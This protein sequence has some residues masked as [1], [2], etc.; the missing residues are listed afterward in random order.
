MDNNENKV[1]NMGGNN[2]GS[3]KSDVVNQGTQSTQPYM[4]E[5]PA[6]AIDREFIVPTDIVRL[7]SGGVFYKNKQSS[8]EIK[9]MTAEDENILTSADLIRSGKVLDVLLEKKIIDRNLRPTDMLTGD[10]NAVLFAIRS[11]GYGDDYIVSMTCPECR[12]EFT[13]TVML[14]SL[15]HKPL[16]ANPDEMGEF[17]VVLP[18]TKKTVK[19]RLMTGSDEDELS[20]SE[21]RGK[22][23]GKGVQI[24]TTVTDQLVRQIM[25]YDG[26]RDK[27]YI[28]RA[29]SVMPPKDSSFLRE[30]I[31]EIAPGVDMDHEFCCTNCRNVFTD[32]VPLT[33][34]LFWPNAKI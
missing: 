2:T 24:S 11:T 13:E 20:K 5:V 12:E 4:P 29:V 15:K 14:S 19:F 25:E 23:L 17:T 16:N 26:K 6:D 8:V 7:P 30:Y 33:L 31:A 22:K 3:P 10:R 34:R 9:Y 21:Q 18:M 32:S 1:I 27:T 28:V